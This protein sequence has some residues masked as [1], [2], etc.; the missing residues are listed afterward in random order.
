MHAYARLSCPAKLA[1]ANQ[2]YA[3]PTGSGLCLGP[4]GLQQTFMPE[5]L[6]GL[7]LGQVGLKLAVIA[8]DNAALVSSHLKELLVRCLT[9]TT[10]WVQWGDWARRLPVVKARVIGGLD[11]AESGKW[12]IRRA[13]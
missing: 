4:C 9:T 11:A 2:P 7:I 1:G 13:W 12:S 3:V 6:P 5:M 8:Q 10:R